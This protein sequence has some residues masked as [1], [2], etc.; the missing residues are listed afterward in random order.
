MWQSMGGMQPQ[1]LE[2]VE[3]PLWQVII[4]LAGSPDGHTLWNLK[5]AFEQIDSLLGG[6]MDVDD[7]D[8]F[9]GSDSTQPGNP[10]KTH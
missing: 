1:Q 2:E 9:D 10:T 3:L 7:I 5:M 6:G 4:S 8:W